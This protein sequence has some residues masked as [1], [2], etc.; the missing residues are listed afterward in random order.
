MN[1]LR[2]IGR[3]LARLGNRLCRDPLDVTPPA[4]HRVFAAVLDGGPPL[5]VLVLLMP[6]GSHRTLAAGPDHADR[7]ARQMFHAAEYAR[8]VTTA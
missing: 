5:V 1:P 3:L 8:Q 2:F 6:D 4:G 7:I